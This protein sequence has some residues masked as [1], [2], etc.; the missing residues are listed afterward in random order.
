MKR[1]EIWTVAGGRD[2]ASGPLRV[3]LVDTRRMSVINTVEVRD[4]EGNDAFEI[5]F[6]ILKNDFYRTAA[7]SETK[8][9]KPIVMWLR[10]YVGAGR[11]LQFA[12]F[13][14]LYCMGLQTAMIG[15]EPEQDRVHQYAMKLQVSEGGKT[16][17]D[18]KRW[19]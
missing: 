6:A 12:L 7:E 4:F 3:S 18:T 2:W 1:G 17:V 10:D 5:P 11:P 8:E 19:V 13:Q 15:Y 16:Q 9:S 14:A